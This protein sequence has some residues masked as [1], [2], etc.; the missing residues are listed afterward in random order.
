M[1][2]KIA[3]API[4]RLSSLA[5]L[6]QEPYSPFALVDP[7]FKQARG[8]NITVLI[9]IHAVHACSLR[10]ASLSARSSASIS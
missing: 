5:R 9:A 1:G 3:M 6:E 4:V 10:I 8:G 7:V 2:L